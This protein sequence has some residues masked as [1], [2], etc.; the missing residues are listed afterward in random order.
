M[1]SAALTQFFCTHKVQQD[2]FYPH[3]PVKIEFLLPSHS[4]NFESCPLLSGHQ[5]SPFHQLLLSLVRKLGP[6]LPFFCHDFWIKA[7]KNPHRPTTSSGSHFRPSPLPQGFQGSSCGSGSE[8]L[9]PHHCS[10][11]THTRSASRCSALS[12]FG[13]II[14]VEVGPACRRVL[15]LCGVLNLGSREHHLGLVVRERRFL[16]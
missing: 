13:L 6:L 3:L 14:L 10:R 15:A 8:L 4:F 2:R 1:R 11:V 16:T 9:V 5:S 7:Y 12:P